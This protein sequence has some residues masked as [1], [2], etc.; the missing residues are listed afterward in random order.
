MVNQRKALSHV[1]S[2]CYYWRFSPSQSFDGLVSEFEPVPNLRSNSRKWNYK[3][4]IFQIKHDQTF[5]YSN[6]CWYIYHQKL[7]LNY[8][9]PSVS[10]FLG[11]AWNLLQIRIVENKYIWPYK[12]IF[13][14]NL[15]KRF[16]NIFSRMNGFHVFFPKKNIT[17]SVI[18]KTTMENRKRKRNSTFMRYNRSYTRQIE[19]EKQ[20]IVTNIHPIKQINS[21]Q[22]NQI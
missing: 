20:E 6:T 4:V 8:Y 16:L 3:V 10:T 14:A 18:N 12:S 9:F 19:I 17:F 21:K 1:S 13:H 22:C 7:Q 15:K 2:C 11:T 5:S